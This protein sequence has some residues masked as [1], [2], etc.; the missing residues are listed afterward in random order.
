[1]FSV[2]TYPRLVRTLFSAQKGTNCLI[3]NVLLA[4]LYEHSQLYVHAFIALIPA[5]IWEQPVALFQPIIGGGVYT[6]PTLLP[7]LSPCYCDICDM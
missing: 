1:M 6:L 4:L 2:I 5:V 7:L 3:Y